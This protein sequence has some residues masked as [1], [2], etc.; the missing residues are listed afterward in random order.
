MPTYFSWR[1]FVPN[2]VGGVVVARFGVTAK[3]K[4]D[5]VVSS[6]R[7]PR[8]FRLDVMHFIRAPREFL[9]HATVAF[10]P[11]LGFEFYSR[12]EWH[13]DPGLEWQRNSP[14]ISEDGPGFQFYLHRIDVIHASGTIEQLGLVCEVI[15]V[16]PPCLH[17]SVI[18]PF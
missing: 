14:V 1:V 17:H 6:V 13:G 7:A 3:T 10:R 11:Y 18:L 2:R 4:N 15:S 12:R 5:G 16:I 9:A 8:S